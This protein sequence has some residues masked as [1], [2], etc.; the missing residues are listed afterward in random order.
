[1]FLLNAIKPV[2]FLDPELST[3]CLHT[4][5]RQEIEVNT[6]LNNNLKKLIAPKA[7]S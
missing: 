1:M 5:S 3:D 2:I 6:W 7:T 4:D